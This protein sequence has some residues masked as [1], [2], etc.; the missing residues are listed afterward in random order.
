MQQGGFAMPIVIHTL[1]SAAAVLI[2]GAGLVSLI[3]LLG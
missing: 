3:D 2:Y 1:A